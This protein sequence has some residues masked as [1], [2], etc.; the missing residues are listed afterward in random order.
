MTGKSAPGDAELYGRLVDGIRLSAVKVC[1]AGGLRV[2][3][4][5]AIE[6][7]DVRPI[8]L[9]GRTKT[10]APSR[11]HFDPRPERRAGLFSPPEPA[12]NEGTHRSMAN[13]VRLGKYSATAR[14]VA[15]G[16]EKVPL[17]PDRHPTPGDVKQDAATD[18]WEPLAIFAGAGPA[19]DESLQLLR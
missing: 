8:V 11:P 17:A 12:N 15:I 19:C 7:L 18:G 16:E 14:G 6:T 13:D 2:A 10:D 1:V 9:H 3:E 5:E 4:L